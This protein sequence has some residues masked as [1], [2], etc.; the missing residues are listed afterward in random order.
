MSVLAHISH[1][2]RRPFKVSQTS[3]FS[4]IFPCILSG[5]SYPPDDLQTGAWP[6]KPCLYVFTHMLFLL[7]LLLHHFCPLIL[8]NAARS[9]ASSSPR[10]VQSEFLQ[11]RVLCLGITHILLCY[12]CAEDT[13]LLSKDH[14]PL[15]RWLFTTPVSEP[16]GSSLSPCSSPL[17]SSLLALLSHLHSSQRDP[18]KILIR[19]GTP[20]LKIL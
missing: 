18:S 10:H 20:L 2:T 16:T 5:L 1:D 14:S 11:H 4:F 15:I 7:L 17:S 12:R 9:S 8:E 6:L 3:L 19:S 13:V